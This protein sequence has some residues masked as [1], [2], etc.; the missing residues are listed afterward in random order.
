M[1]VASPEGRGYDMLAG[2]ISKTESEWSGG[3]INTRV[4]EK[5]EEGRKGRGPNDTD[6]DWYRPRSWSGI[7]KIPERKSQGEAR[8]LQPYS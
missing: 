8:S 5:G 6:T 2:G 7:H 4:G 3:Q 1:I